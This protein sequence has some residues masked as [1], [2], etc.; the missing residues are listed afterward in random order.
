MEQRNLAVAVASFAAHPSYV[1]TCLFKTF[2]LLGECFSNYRI[3]YR[4]QL[5]F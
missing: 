1:H 2:E 3:D 4:R 5:Y